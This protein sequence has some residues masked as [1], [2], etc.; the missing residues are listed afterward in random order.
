MFHEPVIPCGNVSEIGCLHK[1]I[2]TLG[3]VF[4]SFWSKL[5]FSKKMVTFFILDGCLQ[6]CNLVNLLKAYIR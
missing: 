4:Q 5:I 6:Q 1:I 2:F 3:I